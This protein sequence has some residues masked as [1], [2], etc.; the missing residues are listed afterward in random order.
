MDRFIE[1]LGNSFSRFFKA[2]IASMIRLESTEGSH[3]LITK[4]GSLVTILRV[5]GTPNLI[6]DQEAEVLAVEA[7]Q[8]F[9]SFLQKT[10]H[11]IQVYFERDPDR[12]ADEIKWNIEKARSVASAANLDIDDILVER[13]KILPNHTYYERL[14]MVLWSRPALMSK[15]EAKIQ[16]KR[17]REDVKG[18]PPLPD[19]QDPFCVVEGLKARHE[20]FVKAIQA[21]LSRLYINSY[22]LERHD[23]LRAVRDTLYP[24]R[25]SHRWR[26]F[27]PGDRHRVRLS[28]PDLAANIRKQTTFLAAERRDLEQKRKRKQLTEAEYGSRKQDLDEAE[29]RIIHKYDFSD[30]LWPSL[31]SQLLLGDAERLDRDTVRIGDTI[32]GCVD[33]VLAPENPRPLSTLMDTLSRSDQPMPW[34]VSFLI[35]GDGLRINVMNR[36]LASL[37]TFASSDNK[38]IKRSFEELQALNLDNGT[39]VSLRASFATWGPASSPDIVR[40]RLLYLQRAVEGWGNC[41]ANSIVGDPLEGVL[42]SALAIHCGSTAPAAAAPI[43]EAFRLLPWGRPD[44]PWD[45]GSILF[46]SHDG[47]LW[48]YSP[49]SSKQTAWIDL[50]CGVS[51]RGKSVL[52][53]SLNLACCIEA[54]QSGGRLPRISIID[55]G[56]S[57]EGFINLL[58]EA[59]PAERQHE[60][61]YHRLIMA[62]SD[63]INPFDTQLGMRKPLPLEREFLINF[64]TLLSTPEGKDEPFTGMS[65]L[66]GMAINEAYRL[67]SD[68]GESGSAPNPYVRKVD[69]MIDEALGESDIVLPE[70]PLWWDVVDL[71]FERGLYYLA[72]RAQRYAMPTINDLSSA[73]RTP[74]IRSMYEN[75]RVV[76][77]DEPII[78]AANRVISEAVQKWPLLAHPTKLDLSQ[79]RVISLDLDN[80]AKGHG[81]SG[82][83]QTAMVYML[84]AHML[85]RDMFLGRD[86]LPEIPQKY[87]A[88]HEKRFQELSETRKRVVFDEFHRT[89]GAP[90]TRAQV[91]VF[92]R[93]G[94]KYQVQITLASQALDDFGKENLEHATGVWILGVNEID[95][96]RVIET[97]NLSPATRPILRY[98]LNGPVPG[99]GSPMICK[100]S[101]KSG[102]QEQM[103]VN[104]VGPIELWAFSTTVEDAALRERIY[105]RVGPKRGRQLLA[106]EFPGG[107]AAKEIERRRM[108]TAANLSFSDATQNVID[109]MADEM[110]RRA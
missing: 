110:V 10:G 102:P 100:L 19:G 5:D 61:I 105:K 28:S 86:M 66:M 87:A 108:Q 67:K 55:I 48:P 38:K 17:L 109:Q 60:V 8:F 71:L 97:F 22:I 2:D 73:I 36:M 56:R 6:T 58:Q 42:S 80:V 104:A 72:S 68:A 9:A 29:R 15:D 27:L 7:S 70:A 12:A 43:D 1:S 99:W 74:N 98:H 90:G 41:G 95:V 14:Y 88:Y 64:L 33:L 75:T 31:A 93:E 106:K 25:P 85:T 54:Q 34:R 63:A 47:K 51:G 4:E 50:V 94:R 69:V 45:Y 44:S 107:S 23:A 84:A 37:L 62:E 18:M 96:D 92:E 79:A 53:N 40:S 32:F 83:R 46:R 24:S 59:L 49:G 16:N 81:A 21:T 52:L 57:S 77:T 26:P 3:A 89:A 39:I 78:E 91:V 101:M 82:T 30:V 20:A 103:V 65:G 13:A 11:A 76:A 35:E